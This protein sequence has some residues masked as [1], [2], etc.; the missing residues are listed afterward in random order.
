MDSILFLHIT[1]FKKSAL[2]DGIQETE[3]TMKD[4]GPD[5][6]V[7]NENTKW[8]MQRKTEVATL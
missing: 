3:E 7:G 2:R 4:D 6:C 8:K 1:I 5:R